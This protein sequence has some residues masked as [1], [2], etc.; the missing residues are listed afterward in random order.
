MQQRGQQRRGQARQ[1]PH[2]QAY[3]ITGQVH[4]PHPQRLRHRHQL[5]HR[6]DLQPQKPD[7]GVDFP[8]RHVENG[9][10]GIAQYV[11]RQFGPLDRLVVPV[12]AHLQASIPQHRYHVPDIRFPRHRR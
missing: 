3:R 6:C 11:E 9:R 7:M 10:E 8:R 12:Q 5:P 1:C 4:Q 2:Q